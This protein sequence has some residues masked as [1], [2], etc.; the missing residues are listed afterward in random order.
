MYVDSHSGSEWQRQRSEQLRR[1]YAD[2]HS[3]TV[4]LQ[5]LMARILQRVGLLIAHMGQ[6]LKAPALRRQEQLLVPVVVRSSKMR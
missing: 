6:S 3:D 4:F 2:V 1:S 5:I